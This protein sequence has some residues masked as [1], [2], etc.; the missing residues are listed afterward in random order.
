MKA[1]VIMMLWMA[2]PTLCS[3]YQVLCKLPWQSL[4]VELKGWVV[5]VLLP[6]T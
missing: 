1:L 5:V 2:A 6:L 4:Q 3:A